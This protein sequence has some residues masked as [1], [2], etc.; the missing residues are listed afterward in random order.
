MVKCIIK[1]G[2]EWCW[3]GDGDI[4]LLGNIIAGCHIGPMFIGNF[5][6]NN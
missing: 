3:L 5:I 2:L 6:G 4:I 1:L